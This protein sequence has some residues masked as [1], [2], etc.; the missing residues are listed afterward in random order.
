MVNKPLGTNGRQCLNRRTFAHRAM[1][2]T[3]EHTVATFDNYCIAIRQLDDNFLVE[4]QL[5]SDLLFHMLSDL[6]TCY[7]LL[8]LADQNSLPGYWRFCQRAGE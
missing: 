3:G 1:E 4:D 7:S 8:P 2:G 5:F 6:V